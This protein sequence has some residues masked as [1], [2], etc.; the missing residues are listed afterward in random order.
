MPTASI[1]DW[2]GPRTRAGDGDARSSLLTQRWLT[3]DRI[4][5]GLG[6]RPAL[7]SGQLGEGCPDVADEGLRLFEGEEVAAGG[8]LVEEDDVGVAAFELPA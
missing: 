4:G 6:S 7:R 1:A 8:G 3:F 2:Q 5:T